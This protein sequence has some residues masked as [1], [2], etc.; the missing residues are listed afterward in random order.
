[1]SYYLTGPQTVNK[2][3]LQLMQERESVCVQTSPNF[4]ML[5][6]QAPNSS[7]LHN[8]ANYI[9]IIV[10][11]LLAVYL[12]TPQGLYTNIIGANNIDSIQFLYNNNKDI[13]NN[14]LVKHKI[15]YKTDSAMQQYPPTIEL[16]REQLPTPSTIEDIEVHLNSTNPNIIWPTV[17]MASSTIPNT[18]LGH[19]PTGPG[20]LYVE[21]IRIPNP[22][23]GSHT[24][25]LQVG[26]MLIPISLQIRYLPPLQAYL[27][28]PTP[29]P[30]ANTSYST[31]FFKI[32]AI[33]D[34]GNM[35]F[36]IE[37]N[38]TNL[39]MLND[40][41]TKF[42]IYTT[43]NMQNPVIHINRNNLANWQLNISPPDVVTTTNHGALYETDEIE[44][45][46]PLQASYRQ[47][48]SNIGT[49]PF[50]I[51]LSFQPLPPSPPSTT[52]QTTTTTTATPTSTTTAAPIPLTI[53]YQ[54]TINNTT[55]GQSATVTLPANLTFFPYTYQGQTIL[56]T[57]D[58]N[59]TTPNT[60]TKPT[61]SNGTINTIST[62]SYTWTLNNLPVGQ[63]TK[64]L[65]S[66][67]SQ[68]LETGI[69]PLQITIQP[70]SSTTQAP[71]LTQIELQPA[72]SQFGIG[73]LNNQ[74]TTED[75]IHFTTITVAGNDVEILS[76]SNTIT[77]TIQST[78]PWASVSPAITAHLDIASQGPLQRVATGTVNITSPTTAEIEFTPTNKIVPQI[79]FSGA[80][81]IGVLMELR[82]DTLNMLSQNG[83]TIY[84]ELEYG[85]VETAPPVRYYAPSTAQDTVT[86][87]TTY[88][89]V[90]ATT[91]TAT[92]GTNWFAAASASPGQTTL[93]VDNAGNPLSTPA[94]SGSTFQNTSSNEI[95]ELAQNAII[96]VAP[97]TPHVA[98]TSYNQHVWMLTNPTTAITL[99][100]DLFVP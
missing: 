51:D 61:V 54:Q 39:E 65:L 88:Q 15:T 29:L 79:I 66:I 95:V 60:S 57:L 40:L 27:T 32:A 25:E 96:C 52:A 10:A 86:W 93:L 6:K 85:N 36:E 55:N 62:N 43:N 72:S 8:K 69:H 73:Q 12:F 38:Y 97:A 30:P 76:G 81:N 42:Q 77:Y 14:V 21:I 11:A 7:F 92:P 71:F 56:Q 90:I 19:I 33:Q 4:T 47:Y 91:T 45:I 89:S 80:G 53:S 2:R 94:S 18:T 67:N 17:S 84:T 63:T 46:N 24:I 5:K 23:A 50:N 100:N 78:E 48:S 82:I 31:P 41:G 28:N 22:P 37:R 83:T 34:M 59:I 70:P 26:N 87:E 58:L 35:E 75:N 20:P 49:T 68:S 1:M 98:C 74:R 9:F 99:D 44:I 13:N 64:E 3:L 16:I